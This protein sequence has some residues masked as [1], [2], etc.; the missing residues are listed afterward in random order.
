MPALQINSKARWLGLL[1]N[2]PI[3]FLALALAVFQPDIVLNAQYF[4]LIAVI[5]LAI[6]LIFRRALIFPSYRSSAYFWW[7]SIGAQLMSWFFLL[8]LL[9][10][11]QHYLSNP[12]TSEKI[13]YHQLFM[14][15]NY[16]QPFAIT[17]LLSLVMSECAYLRKKTPILN[18][19]FQPLLKK[20]TNQAIGYGIS[21]YFPLS[22]FFLITFLA[23]LIILLIYYFIIRLLPIPL[24]TGISLPTLLLSSLLIAPITS[25]YSQ[26]LIRH[27]KLKHW[28][29]SI[30]I[31]LYVF[32]SCLLVSLF[33]LLIFCI[34]H[35]ALTHFF[36]LHRLDFSLF[37][38]DKNLLLLSCCWWLIIT[39]LQSSLLANHTLQRRV[40]DIIVA[41]FFIPTLLAYGYFF[42]LAQYP[43]LKTTNHIFLIIIATLGFLFYFFLLTRLKTLRGYF[44]G[45]FNSRIQTY[46][47][48]QATSLSAEFTG[49]GLITSLWLFNGLN[50][51]SV[52][53]YIVALP[54]LLI[55]I[56]V[57]I[58]SIILF[59][60]RQQ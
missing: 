46:F 39:P 51:L 42:L 56:L 47:R 20:Y 18:K 3:T 32:Y 21:N 45:F 58:T 31:L 5:I 59:F 33:T 60:R 9:L 37:H 53:L 7:I 13:D 35:Y 28:P 11:F 4:G 23:S 29:K 36:P 48:P 2:A 24:L 22:I 50:L 6:L 34:H 12:V 10:I 41:Q 38:S 25:T 40:Q 49:I 16:L 1:A 57:Y 14:Q 15:F 26:R 43:L 17:T 52:L 54:L 30:L 55:L 27:A 19:L 44:V 8:S